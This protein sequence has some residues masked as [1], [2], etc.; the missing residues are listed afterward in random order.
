MKRYG[1][2]EEYAD[3]SD[4]FSKPKGFIYYWYFFAS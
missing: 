4:I 3:A 1:T 2:P